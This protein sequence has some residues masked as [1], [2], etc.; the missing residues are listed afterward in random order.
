MTQ[1]M[2][3]YIPE[4][5]DFFERLDRNN[6]RP[7]FHAHKAQYDALRDAWLADVDRM[8]GAMT[9]W[10]P[11]LAGQT[12]RGCAYRIYRDTRFSVDKTPL[13]LNFSAAISPW[14]KSAMR[15]G[16]YIET[17][18]RPDGAGLYGG[19]YCPDS[20]LLKKLRHAIVDNIEEFTEIITAPQLEEY[21]PGW[22]G[23]S[24]KTVPKGWPKDHPN[25][26]L[27]RLKDYGKVYYCDKEFFCN[28][29]WPE[30]AAELFHLLKPFNDFLNYSIDE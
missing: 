18:I 6:N 3:D 26:D 4:L 10:E 13:K 27:L 15:A 16:Y 2:A 30:R 5:Y 14:G 11:R 20:A 22:I 9:E 29:D 19:L 25:A 7:W 1:Y 21:F 24:L 23:D 17:G 28:P 12:A 8:I